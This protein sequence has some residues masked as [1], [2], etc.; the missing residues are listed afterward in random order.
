V[1]SVL[2]IQMDVPGTFTISNRTSVP[3]TE[4]V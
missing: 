1:T 4:S 3:G 2:L